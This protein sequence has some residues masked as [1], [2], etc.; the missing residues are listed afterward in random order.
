LE[1][2]AAAEVPVAGDA[3]MPR[4]I[5]ELERRLVLTTLI[6]KWAEAER[7]GAVP[8]DE[9]RP[10][11]PTGARTPA[12]AARLARELARLIDLIETEGIDFAR[13][14]E[15]VPEEYSEHW[16]RTLAFLEIVMRFWPDHLI[17][18]HLLS[19]VEHRRRLLRAEVELL[20]A[21]PPADPVIVAGV[22]Q[23]DAPASELVKTVLAQPNGALVLP[24]LDQTLDD[25]SWQSI[26]NHPE[27]PQ[28]GLK[29]LID[30]LGLS[31][32]DI[33]P[34]GGRKGAS[35]RSA[36][37]TLACEAMRPAGTT[38]LWHRFTS[39]ADKTAM[40]AALTGICAIEAATAEEETEAIALVLREVA[41]TPGRTA[42][43][44]TPDRALA[45]RVS[46]RLAVWG[47]AID[48][49]AGELFPMTA[50]GAFFDLLAMGGRRS[51]SRLP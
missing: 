26:G 2:I 42:M 9:L 41:E 14:R 22:T 15:L 51:S 37:W 8:D 27:H 20:E 38:Q 50:P 49:L 5:G 3:D 23:A 30:G 12:Q 7:R 45:R 17:E 1:L 16:S 25:E 40:A 18:R 47:L 35:A 43:L 21:G 24:A 6:L 31:R 34:L 39:A 28:F 11:G 4:A 44:V 32:R 33:R 10:Y 19:P 29:Q 13:L 46:A 48:D 36:R